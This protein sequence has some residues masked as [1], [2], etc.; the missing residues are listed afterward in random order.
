M[1]V[2]AV[3]SQKGGSGKSTLAVNLAVA[4]QGP[5]SPVVIIDADP[6]GSAITWRRQREAETP[7]VTEGIP[8]QLQQ[9]VS[10]CR[11]NGAGLVIIDT[12]PHASTAEGVI[13]EAAGVADLVVIPTRP[14]LFDITAVAASVE[15]VQVLKRPA[16]FILNAVPVRGPMEEAARVALSGY[17]LSTCPAPLSQRAAFANAAIVGQAVV[18]YE[19]KGKAAGE[20]ARVWR[21]LRRKIGA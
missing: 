17:K 13:R 12:P 10:L 4:A 14:A 2:L 7:T 16:V 15:L 11:D 5:R 3:V 19:P 20:V 8:G 18:E 1:K 9:L 21:W 6:Q